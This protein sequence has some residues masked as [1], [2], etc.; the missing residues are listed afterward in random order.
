MPDPATTLTF[1]PTEGTVIRTPPGTGYGYWVG[2]H[3]VWHDAASGEFAIFYRERT[4]LEQGR[5]GVCRVARSRDGVTFEDAWE[6]SKDELAAISIEVGHCVRDPEG[7]WRLYISYEFEVDRKWRIDV[8]RG[9]D[10]GSL[11][12]QGRR[13]VLSPV[14][15]NLPWIKDPWIYRNDDGYSLVAAVPGRTKPDNT[16][17]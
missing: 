10:L 3:K 4:P 16:A 7:E 15:F 9:T 12:T 5:G 8:I 11:D 17:S 6:A 13:T 14:D 1:D 2:G